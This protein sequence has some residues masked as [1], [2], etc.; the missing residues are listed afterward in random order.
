[1]ST[2]I[3]VASLF[4]SPH[5]WIRVQGLHTTN[6]WATPENSPALGT[7]VD[8]NVTWVTRS[9]WSVYT[10][11]IGST[12]FRSDTTLWTL[13][14]E[15]GL[16][17]QDEQW[18]AGGQVIPSFYSG[19]FS[20]AQ[21][22]D[23]IG[24]TTGRF[25]SVDAHLLV[26]HRLYPNLTGMDFWEAESRL[27]HQR[28]HRNVML[29]FAPHVGIRWY[30]GTTA[31]PTF[32]SHGHRFMP[33]F[34]TSRDR[35]ILKTGLQVGLQWTPDP[36]T[37]VLLQL[38]FSRVFGDSLTTGYLAGAL[39]DLELFDSPYSQNVLGLDLS[40]TW[41]LPWRSQLRI[42]TGL[43]HKEYPWTPILDASEVPASD[44]R[45]DL[46]WTLGVTWEQGVVASGTWSADLQV[47]RNTSN[48]PQW[49]YT[50]V[51]WGLG[52]RGFF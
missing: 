34:E 10:Q 30:P 7:A 38:S 8:W 31:P 48:D 51:R 11:G 49:T 16:E 52:I 45:R 33:S 22:W 20:Q 32:P 35:Q 15:I 44:H 1:M 47:I 42:Q 23:L 13:R 9:R 19:S 37:Q 28:L 25:P 24:W 3:L 29:F 17:Y 14:P 6:L 50:S 46:Q 5:G 12:Y 40:G 21:H 26:R 18:G 2:L 36:W 27:Q 39:G 41:E 43:F 4:T